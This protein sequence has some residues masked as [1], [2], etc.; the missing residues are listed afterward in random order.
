MV[1][2]NG[3]ACWAGQPECELSFESLEWVG[4]KT[5][6]D[7]SESCRDG[8]A[9]LEEFS[10][11]KR[12]EPLVAEDAVDFILAPSKDFLCPPYESFVETES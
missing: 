4:D 3:E 9:V 10:E 5:V 12:L 11:E 6:M 7:E 1:E 2:L 8:I